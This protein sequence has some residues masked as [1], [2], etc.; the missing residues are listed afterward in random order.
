MIPL[1]HLEDIERTLMRFLEKRPGIHP[2]VIPF[3]AILRYVPDVI[4]RMS[5]WNSGTKWSK[6]E[7]KIH[8][9]F[10]SQEK[11]VL[12]FGTRSLVFHI[13]T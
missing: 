9:R 4:S 1:F 7:K 5:K 10:V 13:V 8:D 6:M 3:S 11:F 12:L 2:I